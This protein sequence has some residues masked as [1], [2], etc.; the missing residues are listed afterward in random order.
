MEN[1]YN[2]YTHLSKYMLSLTGDISQSSSMNS[3]LLLSLKMESD[4]LKLGY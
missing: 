1:F 2:P 3:P 4:E